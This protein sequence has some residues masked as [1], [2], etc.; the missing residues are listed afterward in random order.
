[1]RLTEPLVDEI[2]QTLHE[3][4]GYNLMRSWNLPES[5]SSIAMEHHKE[6]FDITNILLVTVRL[7]NVTCK[8]VGKSLIPDPDI[9]LV[10]LP[11]VQALG[12]KEITL[13]ELEIVIEDAGDVTQ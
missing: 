6:D 9:S 13:A 11:E 12:L 4:V 8:K 3:K 1:M 10:L 5:Y 2:L 7:A